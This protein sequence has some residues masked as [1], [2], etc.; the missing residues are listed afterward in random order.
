LYF[1]FF[2]VDMMGWKKKD[3][4]TNIVCDWSNRGRWSN[5]GHPSGPIEEHVQ[6]PIFHEKKSLMHWGD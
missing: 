4:I 3:A 6:V 5:R 2:E 1:F